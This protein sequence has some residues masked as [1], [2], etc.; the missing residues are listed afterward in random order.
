MAINTDVNDRV[1]L[2]ISKELKNEIKTYA[3]E[4]SRSLNGF[5][6]NAIKEYVKNNYSE[7]K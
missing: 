7:K 1:S 2:T 6:I 3:K 4:E 5:I